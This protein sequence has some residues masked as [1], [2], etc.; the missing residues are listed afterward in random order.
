MTVTRRIFDAEKRYEFGKMQHLK[1]LFHWDVNETQDEQLYKMS[2]IVQSAIGDNVLLEDAMF[3]GGV[4]F[5][6]QA[7]AP[8][9][10]FGYRPGIAIIN[11]RWCDAGNGLSVV[12]YDDDA[13]IIASCVVRNIIEDT[14][15]SL[16]TLELYGNAGFED[17][18]V[19]LIDQISG[20]NVRIEFTSGVE[21]GNVFE[22][23]FAT[24]SSDTTLTIAADLSGVVDGDTFILR[25]PAITANLSSQVD[26]IYLCN[27][28]QELDENC[29]SELEDPTLS[30]T[31]TKRLASRTFITLN[32][33][34][35]ALTG[36]AMT[37]VVFMKLGEFERLTPGADIEPVRTA[38]WASPSTSVLNY[39]VEGI[40]ALLLEKDFQDSAQNPIVLDAVI[41]GTEVTLRAGSHI[42]N[43]NGSS[44]SWVEEIAE[45]SIT[46]T[47]TD[48]DNVILSAGTG[49]YFDV[50]QTPATTTQLSLQ[51][52]YIVKAAVSAQDILG[53]QIVQDVFEM[54]HNDSFRGF[55]WRVGDYTGL[56]DTLIIGPGETFRRG[57]MIQSP[58][59]LSIDTSS[60]SN[61]LGGTVQTGWSYIYMYQS[62]RTCVPF[63]SQYRPTING[64][65]SDTDSLFSTY[66][67]RT[68]FCIGMIHKNSTTT[69][70]PCVCKNGTIYFTH[71]EGGISPPTRFALVSSLVV[72]NY[73]VNVNN[74]SWNSTDLPT[75]VYEYEICAEFESVGCTSTGYLLFDIHDLASGEGQVR[76]RVFVPNSNMPASYFVTLPLLKGRYNVTMSGTIGDW[77]VTNGAAVLSSM[78]FNPLYFNPSY[79]DW[80][81]QLSHAT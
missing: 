58:R 15:G 18:I 13:N 9:I 68:A 66:L 40:E 10:S 38:T 78:K 53:T 65:F 12:D 3:L 44:G 60:T 71:L 8:L 52:E 7:S 77:T 57:R 41:G 69:T 6:L 30:V 76:K 5:E 56:S 70:T 62:G 73:V 28:Y 20:K 79:R 23:G 35:G 45:L 39:A 46:L 55:D 21:D 43:A 25:P 37:G 24:L 59:Q 54:G 81:A 29:D 36:D 34:Y 26:E 33:D 49:S 72:S 42:T 67:T 11:G 80:I 48:N 74:N 75:G 51:D 50:T 32:P 63:L 2:R 31:P 16:Y 1:E 47:N 61:W 22:V 27:L 64:L 14:P 19:D 17:W 4:S